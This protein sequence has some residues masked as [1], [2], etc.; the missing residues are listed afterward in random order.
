MDPLA[1]PHG[2]GKTM[3]TSG[4]LYACLYADEFPA[5]ALLRLR[6]ALR[7]HAC[8]VMDGEPPTRFVCSLNQR[9]REIGVVCGMTQV[10]LDTFPNATILPRSKIEET[11][12]KTALLQCAGA[13]SPRIEDRSSDREFLCV[14]DIAGTEKLFG[15]PVQ[16]AETLLARVQALRIAAKIAVSGNFHAAICLVRAE[17]NNTIATIPPGKEAAT[18]APLPLSVLRLP[19]EMDET[20][21]LWGIQTLGMLA[22]LP[23]KSLI[24]RVGQEGWRF[25]Q[26]SRG[27]RPHLFLPLEAEFALEECMELDTP[28]ELLTSLLFVVD[29]MLQ[30]LTMRASAHALALA[31]VTVVLSLE[32]GAQHIRTV[33]PALASND[34][35]MWIKLIHLDME[36]H[37]PQAAILALAVLAEPGK[38]G[39]MQ[40][41]LFS[42]PLPEPARLDVT[43][44]RVRSIVGENNVGRAE[45]KDTHRP[46]SFRLAPFS[47]S[48]TTGE[49]AIPTPRAAMRQLRPAAR[50]TVTLRNRKPTSFTF[51]E[52]RYSVEQAYGPWLSSGD[53]WN[54]DLWGFEQWD[55]I[56]RSR[57]SELLY[58]CLMRD[59]AHNCWEMAALY[60]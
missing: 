20:F 14:V 42:P 48:S 2:M 12:T 58:C 9:A 35:Q 28:I 6:L 15:S 3:S 56:A 44:A 18:L 26:M 13:F 40:L 21:S 43:L 31:A 19:E 33:R 4:E 41:G 46:D 37:P 29:V 60:D 59:L 30:Q 27:E 8:I 45:L 51:R 39:K 23:E 55:L 36:S 53:W 11:A 50:I 5:Q 34:R 10:E 47:V 24:A 32:G 57:D 1:G 49:K 7:D 22:A 17:S 52:K 25:F 54:Q 16:L 38:T